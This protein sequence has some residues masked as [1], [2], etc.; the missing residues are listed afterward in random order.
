LEK[1]GA[2]FVGGNVKTILYLILQVAFLSLACLTVAVAAE[3]DAKND[4]KNDAENDVEN[5]IRRM[6]TAYS[7]VDDY[8]A[9]TTV[10]IFKKD[11]AAETQR[12]LYSFRKPNRVRMDLEAPHAGAILSYPDDEGKVVVRLAGI[13][14][15][16]P[17]H[18]SLNNPR[19]VS[20]GQRIDQTD[21]GLLIDNISH[22]V[23]D[24]RRGPVSVTEDGDLI[25]IEVLAL[26][27][28]VK[29]AETLYRLS[30]DRTLSLP[31]EVEESTRDGFL[32]R[33]MTL[34]NIAIN[35]GL[36]DRFMAGDRKRRTP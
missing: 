35:R 33:I 18:L 9:M 8:Q 27:H 19:L 5:L 3:N 29:R 4:A 17:L 13:A 6:Q 24:E 25:R 36:S 7:T 32:R 21:M 10:R 30:V 20:F 23:T 28:F 14:G 16:F 11:G 34:R 22:S 26:D 15:I 12:F 31:V 1:H 2:P